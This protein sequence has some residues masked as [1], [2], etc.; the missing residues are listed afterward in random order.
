MLN[1][2]Q[3]IDDTCSIFE[4]HFK[5]K[6]SVLS[7]APGRINI[8]GEHTDYNEGLAIPAAIN[9][10]VCTSISISTS[11]F[12]SVYCVNYNEGKQIG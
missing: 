8:I 2:K 5:N 12:S 7:L 9:R 3:L 11:S 4:N 1:K 6:P 10:W